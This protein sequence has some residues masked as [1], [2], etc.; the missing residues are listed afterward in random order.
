MFFPNLKGGFKMLTRKLSDF[1]D[2]YET[3][4]LVL[5]HAKH[6]NDL[7]TE[8]GKAACQNLREKI[9]DKF[10]KKAITG[11][12]GRH[13]QTAEALGLEIIEKN[14]NLSPPNGPF[15]SQ[16]IQDALE[17]MM[18]QE[19]DHPWE[20]SFTKA[21]VESVHYEDLFLPLG[22]NLKY[23]LLRPASMENQLI[24]TSSPLIEIAF[25][26]LNDNEYDWKAFKRCR[27]LDGF[28]LHQVLGWGYTKPDNLYSLH[29]IEKKIKIFR[30][31]EI[32]SINLKTA[33]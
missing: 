16:A 28:L 24:V 3:D 1:Y 17:E 5:R 10:S 13:I 32:D 12:L 19:L 31:E 14:E 4:I 30:P 15:F 21:I 18:K 33:R 23:F 25:H 8:E 2:I 29:S 11:T 9:G 26:A 6:K 27:E 22:R 7:L 20:R